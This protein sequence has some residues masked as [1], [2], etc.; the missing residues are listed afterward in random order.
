MNTILKNFIF[1]PIFLF[2]LSGQTIA[3]TPK[4]KPPLLSCDV[5]VDCKNKDD[6]VMKM[7]MS[8]MQMN[9]SSDPSVKAYAESCLNAL[10]TV[11]KNT[12][13]TPQQ[14]LPTFLKMCNIGLQRMQ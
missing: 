2:V 7:R 10:Q 12:F 9:A 14:D 4:A 8:W 5:N 3:Q 6:A 1:I 13:R 11:Q